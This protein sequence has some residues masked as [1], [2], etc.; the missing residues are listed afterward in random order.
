MVTRNCVGF[1]N[2]CALKILKQSACGVRN[3]DK[4]IW[5]GKP[6]V[7]S[8]A[9]FLTGMILGAVSILA[10]VIFLG[11]F[12]WIPTLGLGAALLMVY[13]SFER[14]ASAAYTI[15]NYGVSKEWRRYLKLGV[16]EIPFD[17]IAAVVVS[18]GA[19]GRILHFGSV[20]VN[21]GSVSFHS[22][23]LTGVRKPEEV[24]RIILVAKERLAN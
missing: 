9:S 14:A 3:L 15:S 2:C 19:L 22:V 17:K 7:L 18:Q 20:K 5:L 12:L 11:A 23:V 10:T 8:F 21:S 24:R 4:V 16:S 1:C 13:F 6:T